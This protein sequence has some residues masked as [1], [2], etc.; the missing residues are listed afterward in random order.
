VTPYLVSEGVKIHFGD[1]LPRLPPDQLGR[2]PL[3]CYRHLLLGQ[4]SLLAQLA[5]LT[6]KK[7]VLDSRWR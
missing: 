6:T 2:R 7:S 1:G 3:Q 5:E 4:P